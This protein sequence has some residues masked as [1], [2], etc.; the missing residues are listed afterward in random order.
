[1]EEVGRKLGEERWRDLIEGER[2]REE[3]R[4]RRAVEE[5]ERE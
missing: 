1:V 5:V 2:E 4:E 3:E